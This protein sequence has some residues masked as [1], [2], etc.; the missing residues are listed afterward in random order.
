MSAGLVKDR[1]GPGFRGAP[2][3]AILEGNLLSKRK[4][5]LVLAAL[6]AVVFAMLGA[7][8][9]ASATSSGSASHG[10]AFSTA[11]L[12]YYHSSTVCMQSGQGM[13]KISCP[14]A[15]VYTKWA[16][17]SYTVNKTWKPVRTASGAVV[18][19]K[20]DTSCELYVSDPW[21]SNGYIYGDTVNTC[22]GSFSYQYIGEQ[23]WRSSWS[24]WRGYDPWNW[25]PDLSQ[26][27]VSWEWWVHCNG[28]GTYNYAQVAYG[29][30][31]GNAGPTTISLNTPRWA[32]GANA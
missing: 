8:A 6:A 18:T 21:L 24:G 4:I 3:V 32:C 23:T 17:K 28:P 26:T 19:P 10:A 30:P 12:P 11:Q 25:T 15:S 5:K 9:P 27:Q 13:A 2:H 29:A 20:T 14:A 7:V 16:H 1:R 31:D 22:V